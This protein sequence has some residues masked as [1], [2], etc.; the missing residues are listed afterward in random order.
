MELG[1][2]VLRSDA[3]C[4]TSV[5]AC[6]TALEPYFLRLLS[7]ITHLMP[8]IVQLEHVTSPS[9]VMWYLC[10]TSQRTFL[11]LHAAHAFAALL[12]TGF[13]FPSLSIPAAEELRFFVL[14]SAGAGDCD[15]LE[16]FFSAL[17]A[18]DIFLTSETCASL[19]FR[20]AT[21]L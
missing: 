16:L 4:A 17:I 12:L 14:E 1:R 13:G 6:V 3:F 8:S 15:E 7:S 9:A 10:I 11:A 19:P 5:L 20:K 2:L 18:A 21:Y